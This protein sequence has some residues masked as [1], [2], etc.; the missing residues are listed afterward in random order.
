MAKRKPPKRVNRKRGNRYKIITAKCLKCEQPFKTRAKVEE[1]GFLRL[2]NRIC[3][4]C[5]TELAFKCGL[6]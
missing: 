1:S 5:K 4:T 2:I 6:F 3:K